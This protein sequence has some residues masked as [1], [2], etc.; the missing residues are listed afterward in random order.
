VRLLAAGWRFHRAEAGGRLACELERS[1]ADGADLGAG[2]EEQHG[3]RREGQRD[4]GMRQGAWLEWSRLTGPLGLAARHETWSAGG[5][6]RDLVRA[7][8][9]MR[10]VARGP[11][12]TSLSLD[13]ALYRVRRGE[14]LYLREAESDRIVLRALSGEGQRTR[15]DFA[16]PLARGTL[17]AALHL[18]LRDGVQRAPRWD[19]EWSRR[20][21]APRD[22]DARGR[23]PPGI[24]SQDLKSPHTPPLGSFDAQV[25]DTLGPD[26]PDPDPF[27]TRRFE[28]A[29]E[30]DPG[31]PG[32]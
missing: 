7:V 14:S 27:G 17:R 25:G 20:T 21:R 11:A 19:L 16:L 5:G 1:L 22:P 15:I 9:A 2:F 18:D 32:P 10:I 29:A 6:L 31:R 23:T 8:T 4:P 30:R 12:G 26:V 28:S 3:V 13:H 24:E